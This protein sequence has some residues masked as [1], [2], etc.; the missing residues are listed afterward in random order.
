[1]RE[2]ED[3]GGAERRGHGLQV[4]ASWVGLGVSLKS[5]FSCF[6]SDPVPV[7]TCPAE[8]SQSGTELLIYSFKF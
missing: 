3:W 1:M 4:S 6:L 5:R 7:F 8:I 2:Q